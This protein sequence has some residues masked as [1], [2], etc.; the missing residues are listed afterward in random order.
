MRVCAPARNLVRVPGL[1]CDVDSGKVWGHDALALSG[2][3]AP[4]LVVHS[5]S[6][7]FTSCN[8]G[9]EM[10]MPRDAWAA[11]WSISLKYTFLN[12]VVCERVSCAVFSVY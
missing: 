1:A 2:E 8:I 3:L 5:G 11:V 10:S 4:H 9:A 6:T 12:A 7:P